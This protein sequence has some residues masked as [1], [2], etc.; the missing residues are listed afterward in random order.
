MTETVTG[1]PLGTARVSVRVVYWDQYGQTIPSVMVD[2]DPDMADRV[3]ALAMSVRMAGEPAGSPQRRFLDA[4]PAPVVGTPG[5]VRDWLEAVSTGLAAPVTWAETKQ[6]PDD[7][8]PDRDRDV[9]VA[10]WH[11]WHTPAQ[12]HGVIAGFDQTEVEQ[13]LAVMIMGRIHADPTLPAL[14]WLPDLADTSSVHHWLEQAHQDLPG[15]VFTLRQTSLAAEPSGAELVRTL[16]AQIPANQR[17]EFLAAHPVDLDDPDSVQTWLD[18]FEEETSLPSL[19]VSA[20]TP[21][22]GTP[23][24]PQ[25]VS[26]PPAVSLPGPTS[27]D[28][29]ILAADGPGYRPVEDDVPVVVDGPRYGQA[30]IDTGRPEDWEAINHGGIPDLLIAAFRPEPDPADYPAPDGSLGGDR[31]VGA[32]EDWMEECLDLASAAARLPQLRERLNLLEDARRQ[33]INGLAASPLPLEPAI[34]DYLVARPSYEGEADMGVYREEHDQWR[35]DF[36]RVARERDILL[37]RIG[38]AVR[39]PGETATLPVTAAQGASRTMV[40]RRVMM[41][42]DLI[43]PSPGRPTLA[44]CGLTGSEQASLENILQTAGMAIVQVTCHGST[45]YDGPAG[46]AHQVLQPGIY[47]AVSPD[48]PGLPWLVVVGQSPI[49]G[50]TGVSAGFPVTISAGRTLAGIGRLRAQAIQQ[51]SQPHPASLHQTTQISSRFPFTPPP[52]APPPGLSL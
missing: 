27:Q 38:S 52:Q 15:L 7:T 14:K 24:L 44:G 49:D 47:E 43:H 1:R 51:A 21:A 34:E 23:A 37:A 6:L 9:T 10:V 2:R 46:G 50:L 26:G 42:A 48:T 12:G 45:L 16:T 5:D 36:M 22:A 32:V 39:V 31:Y 18:A 4:H 17:D 3:T 29:S 20:T 35:G 11:N 19:D 33:L 40:E 28:T 8:D 13:R 25:P 41:M 30:V